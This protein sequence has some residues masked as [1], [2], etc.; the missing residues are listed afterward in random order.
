MPYNPY[1]LLKYRC[2]INVEV[3]ASISAI[4]YVYKYVFKGP[5]R[6]M[7]RLSAVPVPDDAEDADPQSGVVPTTEAVDELTEF[8]SARYHAN[9]HCLPCFE[10]SRAVSFEH[11]PA[12]HCLP[13]LPALH[14]RVVCCM[15]SLFLC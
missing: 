1:L 15:Q 6:A 2:H 12:L 4:K 9:F 7:A 13:F 3:V 5:D 14:M 8:Q 10:D 11:D